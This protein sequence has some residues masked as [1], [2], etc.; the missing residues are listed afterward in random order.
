MSTDR[1]PNIRRATQLIA[2]DNGGV[3]R[4]RSE[5][6][7]LK[8][9]GRW[10]DRQAAEVLEPIDKWLG[11]LTEDQMDKVCNDTSEAEELLAAAPPFTDDLLESYFDEVC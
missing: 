8:E 2:L 4:T 9:Y 3:N 6:Q 7:R 1:Y 11:M 10:L 5:K